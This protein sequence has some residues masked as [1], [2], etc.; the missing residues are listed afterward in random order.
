[1]KVTFFKNIIILFLL[2][3]S[4]LLISQQKIK[5]EANADIV[6]YTNRE[7]LPTTNLTN[8]IQTKD[9]FIWI[10][11]VEG[12][13][14]F[15]GYEFEEVGTDIGLP[16]MQNMYYDST[17][18]VMYFASP[19]KFITFDGKEFKVYTENEGYKIN[20]LSGQF[21]TLV[22]ADSKGR[23][24]IG[25]A[26]PF[27]DKKNNGGL[28][29]FENGKFT[30]YDSKNYPLDNATN[31]IETPYGD[32][33]FNSSGRNTQTREGSYVALFKNGVFKRIDE[34]AGIT[35]Q[36][37]RM[38][39]E[40]NVT[41]IDR[42]GN[43]WLACSGVDLSNRSK[44][45]SGVLMYDGNKFHQ[46][47][48]FMNQVKRDQ[49]PIQVYYSSKINKLFMTTF[50]PGGELFNGNNKSVL[51]FENGKWKVSNILKEIN[52]IRDLKTDRVINDFIYSGVFFLK[53][54][55]YLPERLILQ[56][57]AQN[58]SSKYPA[59]IFSYS[60]NKWKKFDSFETG[61][62]TEINEGLVFRT[63]RGIGIY[64]PN[65]SK[66]LTSKD[67]LLVTQS[68]IVTPYTDY[69][70]L[71]WLSY[72]YTDLPA[73][74][75]TAN[76][77]INVWDGKKLRTITEKDGLASNITFKVFQDSKKRVWIT[78]SKGLTMVREI[79]NSEGEQIFK[80]N[81]VPNQNGKPY[82]TSDVLETKNGDI[83]AWENY[84]RPADV[85]LIE[86]D[87]YLGKFDGEKFVK[88]NSPFS[89]DD[90][91]KKYQLFDLKEDNEGRLWFFGLFSDNI[92]D[93]TS[94]QSKIMLY[95]GKSWTK[96]PTSWN[97]PSE[98]LHY[99]G[100]LKN[101]MYFLTVGG[102]YVFNGN[103]FVNLSDSLNA[104]ADFRILKGAS[105][106][107]TQ[108]E[109][110]AGGNLYIRLRNR[111]LVIF[112]GT[113]LKFYTK[114]DG[115]LS[116]NLSNPVIDE[117]RGE[118]YFSSPSGAIKI[119]GNKFQ[120]FLHDES[121]ASG[122]PY[123][124]A[125]DGFG[126]MVEFYNG[127]GLYINKSEE[128]S[129]P[130]L[131]SSVSIADKLNY[132]NLPTELPYSENSFIFNYAALNY[133]DPKQTTYEHFLEGFDKGW[134]KA[135]NLTFAEYQNLPSGNYTFR[136]RGITSNGEKTNEESYS[137]TINP[138][139]WLTWWA[140]GI[141]IIGFV[142]MLGGIRKYEL[143]R[144]KENENKKF[145]QLENDRKTKELDEAR[146]LQLSMLP[147]A[148]PSLPHLD[149][150]VFMKTATE[151]GGDYYDFHVHLDG[152]LTVILGDATGHG[153]MSGMMVSIM[154]SLFMSD[155]TNKELKPF[156]ENANEAIKDMQLGR[157]MMAL[158]CV[159][160]SNNKI[161]TTN[162]GMP[163]LFIYRKNSQTIEEVVINNM[164]L[165]S[166]KGIVYD[167]KEIKIERGDTLLLMSDGF[168]ELRN[169][170]NEIYGYKRTRN[171]FEESAKKEPEEIITHLRAEARSWTNDK[172]P[173]DD[174]TFVVIKVK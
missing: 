127:V 93:I 99:V 159:Q 15:N 157:L 27:V 121:V 136:V 51:E 111:G 72:S 29:K 105:V 135:N 74:A 101:G 41:A 90:N 10:S 162:A 25:S 11:S 148:L 39:P 37:A 40:K 171:S 106:A 113:N 20:G 164:P 168:A 149:I 76:T 17:K 77:G 147:K 161:I 47:T 64:Y 107:G 131:I 114:K 4:S 108:T 68:G 49:F 2:V 102:F 117:I 36:N 125:M 60:D 55:K 9:G 128:K 165:G 53:A 166:M 26:T 112:D 123:I 174:V 73:Y 63:S 5:T 170:N 50:T 52:A 78:T 89:D 143:G 160:I 46:F 6:E 79:K 156:F 30:V 163:P 16:T 57:T 35:L 33:I 146:Q 122:G 84:V 3:F 22:K 152:T 115:L 62:V 141:Y 70:G 82:N 80:I 24:W 45:S 153:M 65:Y 56:S 32:L 169:E 124:S 134:S 138:P 14:R 95:D 167:I 1:M 7:G 19:V 59:Q 58:Q 144:R 21:I 173:D 137:F 34:S 150:A 42:D 96:P 140:Y 86:A 85:N 92:K 71:V 54:N 12:T 97:V 94:I 151:V 133:K 69:S 155:R 44:L 28:T 104:N 81:S 13:Y 67:G 172:E 75:L 38:Y 48:E 132:Y 116:T 119:N 43:T 91:N 109:I 31:F 120:T 100:N 83:Y 98:Q 154:K 88:L 23:I 110:Q 61:P 66:M 8:G 103:N 158:T 18:N 145:L 129:Y 118:V 142:G 87:Y 139:F 130:L 126:N